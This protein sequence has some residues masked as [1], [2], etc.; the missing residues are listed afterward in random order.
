MNLTALYQRL[1]AA[2]TH[3][4]LHTIT[5]KIIALQKNKQQHAITQLY[6]ASSGTNNN[7][8]LSAERAFY[9]LMMLYHPDRLTIFRADIDK[10]FSAKNMAALQ[11]YA[12]IFSALEME[13]QFVLLQQPASHTNPDE[14]YRWED[15]GN[16]FHEDHEAAEQWNE[17]DT[18]YGNPPSEA[19]FFSIFKRSIYGH[20]SIDL[21]FYYLE[22][23]EELEMDGYGIE[24][25]DGIEHCKRIATLNFTHNHI[26]DISELQNLTALQELF[27]SENSIGYIDALSFTIHLRMADLSSNRITDISPLFQLE[28][29][30]FVN[31]LGNQIPQK[32]I[33]TLRKN[34]VVVIDG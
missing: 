7:V 6:Q 27:L 34:G 32:Q 11:S 8:K 24:T 10:Q 22:E 15:P 28:E 5:T 12:R 14:D 16:G 9:Q 29:L 3:E 31:V 19:D 21:P 30:D 2:Y 17:E 33:D 26:T 23:L 25:L 13:Q 20:E 18:A 4:N 1:L